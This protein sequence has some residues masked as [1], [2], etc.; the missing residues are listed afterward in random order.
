MCIPKKE[1]IILIEKDGVQFRLV[2]GEYGGKY[3]TCT[4]LA[5]HISTSSGE[6]C[7]FALSITSTDR[8]KPLANV[9][10]YGS[11]LSS[12]NWIYDAAVIEPCKT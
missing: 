8:S 7:T 2:S 12:T 3:S 10:Q 9:L 11:T 5:E 6:W 4:P 1:E